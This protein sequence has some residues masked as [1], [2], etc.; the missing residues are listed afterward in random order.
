V[1]D[2]GFEELCGISDERG[3]C[4]CDKGDR[5][6]LEVGWFPISFKG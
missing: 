5:G 4:S 3:D 2:A 1:L 6:C